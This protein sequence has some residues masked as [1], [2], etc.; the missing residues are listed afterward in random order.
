MRLVSTSQVEMPVRKLYLF[1]TLFMQEFDHAR[2]RVAFLLLRT[3]TPPFVL[4]ERLSA[5][6]FNMDPSRI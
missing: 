3:C 5:L 4:F 1:S 2:H 6:L